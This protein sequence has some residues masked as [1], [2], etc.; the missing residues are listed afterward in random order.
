MTI[1]TGTC[2]SRGQFTGKYLCQSLFFNKIA[3]CRLG[4]LLEIDPVENFIKNR[5]NAGDFL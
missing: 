2:R 5:P 1:A 4:T 3:G